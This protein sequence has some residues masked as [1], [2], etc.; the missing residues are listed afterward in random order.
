[1]TTEKMLG[2]YTRKEWL[3]YLGAASAD[4][5]KLAALAAAT[6]TGNSLK[7]LQVN[8][9]EDGWQF[10]AITGVTD[11]DKGDIVVSSSGAVWEFDSSVVTA[12]A[13]TFLDD[14]DAT[15]VRSTLGLGTAAPKNTGTFGNTIPLL[16]G[17]NT[18]SG[19]S[20][21]SASTGVTITYSGNKTLASWVV[22]G[23]TVFDVASATYTDNFSAAAS[24]I[25]NRY[26]SRF[27]TPTFA[28]TNAI[29]VTDAATF[30]IGGAPTA[31][32]N[33]TITRAWAFYIVAGNFNLQSGDYYR[34]GTKVLGARVTGFSAMT[35]T[36]TKTAIATYTAPTISNPP[37]QAEVQAI[38]DALQ[39]AMRRLKALDDAA[40]AHGF[41]G[42]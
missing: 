30:A 39:A 3:T 4:D 41:T 10:T 13:R 34:A 37:T 18:F 25:S 31:G 16:D 33:T 5:P 32:T 42:A 17:A 6:W 22:G 27:G 21:F 8:A 29:T 19:A 28:S 35:G 24:V 36:A 40:L 12:F 14:A 20:T 2:G 1:M 15:A 26:A 23:G 9:T 38:A 11:G 7:V